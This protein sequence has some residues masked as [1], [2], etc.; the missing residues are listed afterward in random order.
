MLDR[1]G[2]FPDDPK[3]NQE[4]KNRE[5]RILKQAEVYQFVEIQQLD[6]LVHRLDMRMVKNPQR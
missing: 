6:K 4:Q 2:N 1:R 3:K 5:Q